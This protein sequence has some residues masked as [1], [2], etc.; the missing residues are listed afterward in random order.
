MR[1]QSNTGRV[2]DPFR[3]KLFRCASAHA[4]VDPWEFEVYPYLTEALE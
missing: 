4:Q 3:S 1:R 2:G